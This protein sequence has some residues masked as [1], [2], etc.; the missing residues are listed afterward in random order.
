MRLSA[1]V[2]ERVQRRLVVVSVALVLLVAVVVPV[3]LVVLIA[4]VLAVGAHGGALSTGMAAA[5]S[6]GS[7]VC[8]TAGGSTA[9]AGVAGADSEVAS[10]GR[11]EGE[12][13]LA[14][15]TSGWCAILTSSPLA[16]SAT[17]ESSCASGA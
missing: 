11:A 16:C 14:L 15:T 6:A 17:P 4:L 12:D 5:V 3:V 13:E 1:S 9:V 2:A 8:W 10:E 7:A